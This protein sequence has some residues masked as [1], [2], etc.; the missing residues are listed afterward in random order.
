MTCPDPS[1][2]P[3]QGEWHPY[4]SQFLPQSLSRQSLGPGGHEPAG[5]TEL[6][7]PKFPEALMPTSMKER[8]GA[9][10]C[11]HPAW[12]MEARGQQNLTGPQKSVPFSKYGQFLIHFCFIP[13][14]C[15]GAGCANEVGQGLGTHLPLGS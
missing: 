11:A 3:N 4:F 8:K 5:Q 14:S 9:R 1:W 7:G 15:G 2:C 13:L 10:E 6:I 12:E